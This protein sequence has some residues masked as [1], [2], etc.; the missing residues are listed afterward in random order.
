MAVGTSTVCYTVDICYWECP[1]TEVPLYNI[2]ALL[3][4]D[5]YYNKYYN[6]TSLN[7][8]WCKAIYRTRYYAARYMTKYF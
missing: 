1:L 7:Q 3:I 8:E 5:R 2:K 4:N 6:Y